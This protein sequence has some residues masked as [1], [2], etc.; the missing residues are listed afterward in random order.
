MHLPQA[1][2]VAQQPHVAPGMRDH[3]NRLATLLAPQLA[4]GADAGPKVNLGLIGC[5]GRGKWI[6]DLFVKHGGYNVTAVFDYFADRA[7]EAGEK[8]GVPAAGR[9]S[10]LDGY[11]RL[12][13]QK[14]VDAVAIESPPYFHPIHAAAAVDAGVNS[15]R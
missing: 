1:V 15:R 3:M 9:F 2:H 14:N 7:N 12:L 6:T 4:T 5:G 8:F 11:R 10:G 13:E